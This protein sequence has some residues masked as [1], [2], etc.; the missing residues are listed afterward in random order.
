VS[1]DRGD[2]AK[3]AIQMKGDSGDL[4][5]PEL[6]T[7]LIQPPVGERI[8]RTWPPEEDGPIIRD[9]EGTFHSFLELTEAGVWNYRWEASGGVQSAENGSV[10]V[11]VDPFAEAGIKSGLTEPQARAKLALMVLADQDPVLS[12]DQLGD[13]VERARRPDGEG[14]TWPDGDAWTPTW[15]LDAA[16]AEGWNR[17]AAMAANR[18]NFGEDGQSFQRAEVYANCVKQAEAYARRSMGSIPYASSSTEP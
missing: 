7:L 9:A 15:D 16:A 10:V 18:F 5:D 4:L 14:S 17:K 1:Y 13:L 3:L 11:A 6:L 8:T 2:V 12:D